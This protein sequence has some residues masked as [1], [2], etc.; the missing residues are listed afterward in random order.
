M[1]GAADVG[2]LKNRPGNLQPENGLSTPVEGVDDIRTATAELSKSASV[3]CSTFYMY[4]SEK[5][6]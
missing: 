1:I 4:E 3:L 2:L 5:W 6:E